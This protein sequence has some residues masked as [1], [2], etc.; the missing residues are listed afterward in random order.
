MVILFQSKHKFM[1]NNGFTLI[2]LMIVI[3]IIGVLA[4]IGIPS[5][6]SYIKNSQIKACL[7]ETKSYANDTYYLLYDQTP[8]THPQKPI[9]HS[10]SSITDASSW[11]ES[12]T[13]LMIEAK[14]KHS[15]TVD[16]R[17]DLSKGANCT[18]IP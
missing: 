17:C 15:S 8:E 7:A 6:L 14:S 1:K 3:A 16:I 9:Y 11:N 18:I 10:C 12:T 4:S 5:Y 2:E 13:N